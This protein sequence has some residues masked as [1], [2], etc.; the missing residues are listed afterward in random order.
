MKITRR[1]ALKGMGAAAISPLLDGCDPSDGIPAGIADRIENVVVVMME[2]RSFDHVFGSLSLDEGRDDV[3]GLRPGMTNPLLDDTPV[4]PQVMDVA[5]VDNPP[6]LWDHAHDQW[7][8]GA[9][10]GFARVYERR[11]GAEEAHQVMGYLTRREQPTSYA[12]ADRYALCQRWHSSALAPTWPNRFYSLLGTSM[13]ETD[14]LPVPD[15][16][17]TL[18]E[19]VYQSGRTFGIYYGNFTFAVLPA[20]LSLYDP[21]FQKYDAFFEQ[22]AAGT[23]P[24]FSWIDPVFGRNDDHPPAHPGAGQVFL[25]SIYRALAESPQWDRTLLVVTYDEHGGFFDHVPPPPA[26]DDHTEEGFGVHGFRVP[27]FIAGPWVKHG[28][29]SDTVYDHTSIYKTL[30]ELWDLPDI[31][32][33]A[34]AANSFLDVIDLERIERGVPDAPIELT[35]LTLTDD[36]I[37][38]A[39]C[40]TDGQDFSG[41]LSTRIAPNS[42]QPE[43]E[44]YLR[45]HHA[46][47]PKNRLDA[48]DRVYEEFLTIARRLGALR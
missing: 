25:Q 5:C 43:M 16:I 28:H 1:S 6:H 3:D 33:R 35:P 4:S 15:H 26:A 24:N 45:T 22:A 18:F 47:H 21:E 13:G 17:P 29:V 14:S 9:N 40:V 37:Y 23:L 46:G 2:N 34:S 32:T 31:T 12:L 7:N 8:D 19:Q 20:R 39:D 27:A 48:T 42:G 10:D 11:H 41:G 36:E 38:A 30:A 44:A